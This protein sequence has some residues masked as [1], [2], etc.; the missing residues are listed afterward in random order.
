MTSTAQL[1]RNVRHDDPMAV[2]EL[3]ANS[4]RTIPLEVQARRS[5]TYRCGVRPGSLTLARSG[6]HDH[7]AASVQSDGGR[8][9]ARRDHSVDEIFDSFAGEHNGPVPLSFAHNRSCVHADQSGDVRC[10]RALTRRSE[11]VACISSSLRSAG[12]AATSSDVRGSSLVQSAQPRCLAKQ[13]SGE[14]LVAHGTG[15]R[16]AQPAASRRSGPV[17]AGR[18]G[19]G[20]RLRLRD[21]EAIA[22][23][24]ASRSSERV[25]SIRS[26]D[27]SS[28]TTW[29]RQSVLPAMAAH[30]GSTTACRQ[31]ASERSRRAYENGK[32][33]VTR[34]TV[35]SIWSRWRCGRE[36]VH[37]GVS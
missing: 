35:L 1:C 14:Y 6:P 12:A 11:M 3:V 33:R 5:M 30:R 8:T 7:T 20:P 4:M 15:G 18:D 16:K 22:G 19:R 29:S 25:R 37:R 27:G 32:Q 23:A 10:Q 26:S 24:W 13:G 28:V 36:R 21:D 2:A 9:P 34:S 31:R 17:S